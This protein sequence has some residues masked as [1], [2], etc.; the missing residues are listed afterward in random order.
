MAIRIRPSRNWD[1]TSPPAIYRGGKYSNFDGGTRVPF[2]MKWPDHIK[3]GTTSN[4]LV[5]QI[6]LLASLRLAH[7][8][9]D[10]PNDAPDSFNVLPAMLG[11]SHTRGE[12]LS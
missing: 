10:Y 7:R 11:R 5:D 3:P 6:D 4:A 1:P 12:P 9:T 8:T 2:I